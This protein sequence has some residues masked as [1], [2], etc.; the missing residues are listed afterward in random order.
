MPD[1]DE[2]DEEEEG[3]DE[4]GGDVIEVPGLVEYDV[5]EPRRGEDDDDKGLLIPLT[6]GV[7]AGLEVDD[8]EGS[9][10]GRNEKLRARE[11]GGGGG[12]D[13]TIARGGVSG[14]EGIWCGKPSLNGR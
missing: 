14:G 10:R 12:I 11:V 5:G 3:E 6:D 2:E 1:A 4:S 9:R 8:E 7:E 13:V